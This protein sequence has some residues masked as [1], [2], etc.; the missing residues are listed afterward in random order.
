MTDKQW[1][2]IEPLL[3]PPNTGGRREKHLRR[4]IVNA[5]FYVL[6]TGCSWRQLA[7]DLPPWQTVYWYFK[8]WR[9]DGTVDRVHDALRDRVRD[10]D[11]RDPLVSAGIV[12]A[13]AVKGADTVGRDSRGYDAGK[14]VNGRKRHVV[15]D[16]LG[17]LLVVI[18]TAANVQD[19]DGGMQ[20]LRRLRFA[21]PSVA[22]VFADG[23]YAG[24]LVVYAHQV[25]RVTIELVRKPAGQQG[26]AAL[27]RRWVVERT[28][29]W[30][31]RC[32]RLDHDYERLPATAEAMTKWAMIGIMTR[33]L[34]PLPG[35][36]P[37]QPLT[38]R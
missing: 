22:T 34:A 32:R 24:R 19:R 14:R 13:Q 2:L 25:L 36:R 6:R 12:D 26:F 35:R 10:S 11:G 4:E 1:R 28:L 7:H 16:T 37:W 9:D 30:I 31:V 3:P 17:L 33:R 15:V 5:I 38:A 29:A 21:M 8:R 18:V 23:G 20:V 27:P